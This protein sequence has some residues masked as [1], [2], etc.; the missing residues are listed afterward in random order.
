MQNNTNYHHI[1][2]NNIKVVI[3]PQNYILS[4]ILSS[5]RSKSLYLYVKSETSELSC[6]FSSCFY[7]SIYLTWLA[8]IEHYVSF[9][10][11]LLLLQL[12]LEVIIG[13][14]L[15]LILDTTKE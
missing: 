14:L 13:I 2:F 15:N 10:N 4:L 9:T 8:L 5:S 12:Y 1:I 7:S 6:W 11:Y 3:F